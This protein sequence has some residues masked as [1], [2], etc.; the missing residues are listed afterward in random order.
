L[1]I[2]F[3]EQLINKNLKIYNITGQTIFSTK[4]NALKM[5]I[6]ISFLSTAIYYISVDDYSEII[7]LV[8]K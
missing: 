4:I 2:A 5:N 3:N 1:F 6:N 7:K 8:K